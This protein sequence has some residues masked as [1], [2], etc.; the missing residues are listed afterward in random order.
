MTDNKICIPI[1]LAS[2]DNYAP[3]LSIAMYSI[4]Y[5]TN[6][7]INFYVLDDG[8][9][10]FHKR[11]ISKCLQEKFNS[12][13]LEF[14]PLD[15][16]KEFKDHNITPNYPTLSIYS[17]F[18]IPN[19]KPNINKAIYL[20]C[21]TIVLD[22]ITK[23][24]NENLDGYPIGA[25]PEHKFNV[26][27]LKLKNNAQNS[28]NHNYFN[29]GV[30]LIDCEKW[31]KNNFINDLLKISLPKLLCP[32]QDILNNYFDNNYKVLSFKYNLKSADI[33]QNNQCKKLFNRDGVIDDIENSKNNPV[34]KHFN[35]PDRAWQTNKGLNAEK[36]KFFEDFW[37]FAKMTPFYNGLLN[38]FNIANINIK[39]N[40]K[41]I[42]IKIFNIIPFIN[43]KIKNNNKKIYLFNFL[44]ILTIKDKA[45]NE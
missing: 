21:D 32:D 35:M 6:N 36:I 14:I 40:K 44:P 17:R 43:I 33:F 4:L 7:F 34:I 31:R 23:L 39:K 27:V 2:D 24:Y 5:N 42:F 38:N 3:L 16:N 45:E 13:S 1:F 37:F 12:F 29:S 19:I 15:V 30:L 25:V 41:K 8:I 22:D 9:A 11:Q 18:L 20:D 28:L 10:D 26:E